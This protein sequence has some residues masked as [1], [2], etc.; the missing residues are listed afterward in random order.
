M[1]LF[2]LC[3]RTL[4]PS[5]DRGKASINVILNYSEVLSE[6]ES[7]FNLSH[8]ISIQL[9]TTHNLLILAMNRN[10]SQFIN[11]TLD[12][13][14]II[15]SSSV[16]QSDDVTATLSNVLAAEVLGQNSK[17]L[18]EEISTLQYNLTQHLISLS[19]NTSLFQSST[20]ATLSSVDLLGS[21]TKLLAEN[22]TAA[23]P[24]FLASASRIIDQINYNQEVS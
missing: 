1:Y 8:Q 12:K 11:Q 10:T 18:D 3:H 21:K 2:C 4:L 6:L 19:G 17:L 9:D 20:L 22:S 24:L 16:T 7:S 14:K 13:S 5:L 23:L 15:F